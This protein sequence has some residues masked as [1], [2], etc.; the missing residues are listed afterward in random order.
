[1][2]NLS[3]LVTFHSGQVRNFYS[4]LL[5]QV[6]INLQFCIS[7][8][9]IIMNSHDVYKTVGILISML[10]I[11]TVFNSLCLVS[12]CLF[13]KE[14]IHVRASLRSLCIICSAIRDK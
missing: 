3:D 6:K 5:G 11:Y 7:Y 4:L 10:L 1:M 13:L 12:Y 8:V 14:F 9:V 2:P